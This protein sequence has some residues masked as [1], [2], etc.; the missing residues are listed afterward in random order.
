[1]DPPEII[2]LVF[3]SRSEGWQDRG[4]RDSCQFLTF[5]GMYSMIKGGYLLELSGLSVFALSRTGII[6]LV[7]NSRSQDLLDSWWYQKMSIPEDPMRN[8]AFPSERYE[9]LEVNGSIGFLEIPEI[10]VDQL[11]EIGRLRAR[12]VRII[13]NWPL[14]ELIRSTLFSIDNLRKLMEL[15]MLPRVSIPEDSRGNQAFPSENLKTSESI[16]I[17]VIP[18]NSR[19]SWWV[20]EGNREGSDRNWQDCHDLPLSL[21]RLSTLFSIE[22]WENCQES[23]NL[24]GD[25]YLNGI[26]WDPQ[27]EWRI[28]SMRITRILNRNDWYPQW[29]G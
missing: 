13:R 1:M 23:D 28:S 26:D 27:W 29:N 5:W 14:E 18:R 3:N 4:M 12:I 17:H 19:H 7:L 16:G 22:K 2:D 25:H 9:D 6:H 24:Q 10:P 11:K 21:S 15:L 20:T 8:Q